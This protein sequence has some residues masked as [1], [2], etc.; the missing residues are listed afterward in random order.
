MTVSALPPVPAR[1]VTAAPVPPWARRAAA[2]VLWTSMPSALWR[3]AVVL[4]VPLG[5]A[6]SEYDATLV[7]GWGYLVV[8]VVIRVPGSAGFLNAGAGMPLGRG[9][10][11]VWIPYL[12]GRRIPVIAAVVPAALGALACTVYGVLFVWTTLHADRMYS[13]FVALRVRP[14]GRG[15]RKAADD[16]EPP[17]WWLLAEWPAGESEPVQFWLSSLPSEAPGAAG[18]TTSPSSLPPVLFAP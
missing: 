4:G 17:Q 18:T 1:L 11:A 9:M 16:P 2:A 6:E 10:A 14:A 15:V 12:R 8:P 13:R 7:P 3:F 5:L